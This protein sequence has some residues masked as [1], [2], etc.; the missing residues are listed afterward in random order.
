MASGLLTGTLHVVA[1]IT[2]LSM[3]VDLYMTRLSKAVA[4]SAAT[5]AA[6][7]HNTGHLHNLRVDYQSFTIVN[8]NVTFNYDIVT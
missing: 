4:G 8:C 3:C 5:G 6:H 1:I 2:L 7:F